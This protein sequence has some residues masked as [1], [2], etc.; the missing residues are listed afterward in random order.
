MQAIHDM[1][2]E[3]KQTKNFRNV[4]RKRRKS[5]SFQVQSSPLTTQ[6]S[7]GAEVADK[8]GVPAGFFLS[9][10]SAASWKTMTTHACPVFHPIHQWLL[11]AP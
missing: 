10:F 4:P 9:I 3:N 6:P 11:T 2:V 1:G 8:V 7:P 5:H